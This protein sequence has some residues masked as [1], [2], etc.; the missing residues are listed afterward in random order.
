MPT[1]FDLFKKHWKRELE[2]LPLG[3]QKQILTMPHLAE[4]SLLRH[5][6][7]R[8]AEKELRRQERRA[9]LL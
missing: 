2:R 7:A 3:N 8:K 9:N 1:F 6:A 4:S 5:L